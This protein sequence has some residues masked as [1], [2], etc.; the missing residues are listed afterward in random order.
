MSTLPFPIEI[1]PGSPAYE[2]V[3]QAVHRAVA[4]GVLVEGDSFPSVRA[5]GK[6]ARINPNTAHKVVQ[7]LVAEGTLEVLPGRGTRVAPAKERTE[8]Q[9]LE[10]IHQPLEQLV[11]EARRLGFSENDLKQAIEDAWNSLDKETR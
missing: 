5:L 1:Q 11:I 8:G 9:R 2:Q 10:L 7:A 6:A 3:I 4:K